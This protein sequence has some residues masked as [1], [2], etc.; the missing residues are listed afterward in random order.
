MCECKKGLYSWCK[1]RWRKAH[2]F[3]RIIGL[4]FCASSNSAADACVFVVAAV[5]GPLA[6]Q[7]GNEGS[8]LIRDRRRR[9][10]GRFASSSAAAFAAVSSSWFDGQPL[11]HK[12]NIDPSASD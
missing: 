6:S 4:V 5:F 3:L 11:T 1:T 9:Q 8:E 2:L 7:L 12:Q 10:A